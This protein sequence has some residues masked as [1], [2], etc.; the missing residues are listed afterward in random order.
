MSEKRR[1]RR[2]ANTM[3]NEKWSAA[4]TAEDVLGQRKVVSVAGG[5]GTA[6]L[7]AAGGENWL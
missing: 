5:G 1:P 3:Q 6:I 2:I 7:V 4:D